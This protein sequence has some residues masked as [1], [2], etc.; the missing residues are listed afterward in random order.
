MRSVTEECRSDLI[1]AGLKG[2]TREEVLME[3]ASCLVRAGIVK[4]EGPLVEALLARED[5]GSTGVGDGVAIPHARVAAIE[6]PVL[7]VGRSTQGV[8]FRSLDGKPAD[9]FFLILTPDGKTGEYLQA[10]AQISRLLRRAALREA[11]RRADSAESILKV[12][13]ESSEE[14]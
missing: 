9:L 5:L 8:D 7:V 2:R 10:L 14:S 12:L 13:K 3:L 11:L 6:H 4:E 1:L